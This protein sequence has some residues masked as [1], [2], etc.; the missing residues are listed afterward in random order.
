MNQRVI[1]TT[2]E[3]LEAKIEELIGLLD[4]LDGDP[5]IEE[6]NEHG[7]NILD[8]PHDAI[9]EGND[10]P[11]LGWA[12]RDGQGLRIGIDC[13]PGDIAR[14]PNDTDDIGVTGERRDLRFNG[15]GHHIGRKLICDK[16]KDR[17]KLET[18]LDKTR[19][20]PAYGN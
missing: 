15:D 13:G 6:E 18:A 3:R 1:I 8:V 7:G 19:V 17:R 11:T 20:S 16:I 5:D 10:E 9:D 4:L 2:R 14:D 12:E